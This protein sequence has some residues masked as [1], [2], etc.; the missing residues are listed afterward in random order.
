MSTEITG[1]EGQLPSGKIVIIASRYN[2]SICDSLVQGSLK[3]LRE[4]G[5]GDDSLSVIRVPGAWELPMVCANALDSVEVIATV[6]LGCVIKGETTH[7]EHINRSVSDAI[8]ELGLTT[9]KPIGF[10]LLTC[11]T[12]DQA[13]QRSGGTVGNKGEEAAD[14]ALELLRLGVKLS[15]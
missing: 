11:N 12:L 14:A 10:G 2:E 8:M 3:T 1:T 9:R 5:Y 4:A 6:V 7:D 13:L 15:A